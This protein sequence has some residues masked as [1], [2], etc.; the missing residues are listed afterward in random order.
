MEE[1]RLNVNGVEVHLFDDKLGELFL[2]YTDYGDEE[3]NGQNYHD[4]KKLFDLVENKY[5]EQIKDIDLTNIYI[6][7][8][9]WKELYRFKNLKTISYYCY[10][11]NTQFGFDK[12]EYMYNT[13]IELEI[14]DCV[15]SDIF[16]FYKKH[17]DDPFYKNDLFD[18]GLDKVDF[19]DIDGLYDI[20]VGEFS[21][22]ENKN[23]CEMIKMLFDD[24]HRNDDEVLIFKNKF[25]EF[26]VIGV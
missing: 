17:Q 16:E 7:G 4:I 21:D 8:N 13:N 25:D 24:F 20:C 9:L 2:I 3:S 14:D 10:E 1:I 5:Y 26:Y 22:N 6:S 18:A 11:Q 15:L 12:L 23:L 19:Y